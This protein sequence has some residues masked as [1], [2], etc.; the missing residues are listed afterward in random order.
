M[1]FMRARFPA[2]VVRFQA[3]AV[4]EKLARNTPGLR[5][6]FP[7]RYPD[8]AERVL[9]G[10][11]KYGVRTPL[12]P[13]VYFDSTATTFPFDVVRKTRDR[14]DGLGNT[15]SEG[16]GPAIR[17]GAV[18]RRAHDEVLRLVGGNPETHAVVLLGSGATEAFNRVA[19]TLF[20]ARL[21]RT[22]D[23]RDMVILDEHAHHANMLPFGRDARRTRMI[24]VSET[25]GELDVDRLAWELNA[26][27]GS[28]R[29][30]SFT[31]V[32]NITGVVNPIDYIT[33]LAHAAGA[34]ATMDAAQMVAHRPINMV[35]M[36]VDRLCLSAHK[37]YA[38]G[39]PGVLVAPLSDFGGM[40]DTLGGGIVDAVL[41][42]K[43]FWLSER[44][45]DRQ[46]AGT[47]NIPGAAVLATA[48]M[49][50]GAIGL[51]AI[52]AHERALTIKLLQ[53][54]AEIPGVK[55]YAE[56]DL[57]I[58]D[59]VGVVS[60]N[61]DGMPHG[62]V[63]RALFDLFA[64][65]DRDGCGCAHRHVMRLLGMNA[66]DRQVFIRMIESG[67]KSKQPGMVRLSLGAYNNDADVECALRTVRYIATH[68][69]RL[70]ADYIVMRDGT[71][72]RRD[73]WNPVGRAG[74]AGILPTVSPDG[75]LVFAE[76]A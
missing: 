62:I 57:S 39:G 73:G 32:N 64:V 40:P 11:P 75:D 3:P 61:I 43:R 33:E 71:A 70:F 54:L 4:F 28:V 45:Q 48:A 65:A 5:A 26:H 8:L 6:P 2:E 69:D 49:A 30:V 55:I 47:P 36:G 19:R 51:Q 58:T 60:F 25:T 16:Q 31:G 14:A 59:R 76:L 56:T 46:E 12:R 1:I 17:A 38:P 66:A 24:P 63:G 44:V 15:H 10:L 67:D 41:G 68:R 53:G 34:D 35:E 18:F 20:P 21:G 27:R 52:A 50:L 7:V 37:M 13:L 9:Q 42:P 29:T 22:A 74:A 23:R 72:V